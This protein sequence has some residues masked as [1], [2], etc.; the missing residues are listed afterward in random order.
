MAIRTWASIL[1]VA[2]GRRAWV[3]AVEKWLFPLVFVSFVIVLP[4]LS[5]ICGFAASSA[6]LARGPSPTDVHRGPAHLPAFAYYIPAAEAMAAACSGCSSR[7][8][9]LLHLSADAPESE[10]AD[11][12]TRVWLSIP[13]IRAFG[14][15][16]VVGKTGAIT[17]TGSSG[18][19]A[20]VHS[21]SALLRVPKNLS[22]VNHTSSAWVIPSR[23]FVE[24]CILGWDNIPRTLLWYF[25][26][27]TTV[28]NDLR[29][30]VWDD[31]P[32]M[33]PHSLTMTN[34]DEMTAWSAF[35]YA[36]PLRRPSTRQN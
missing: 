11:L 16:D 12:A 8:R 5:A 4:F 14:N 29:F 31:P 35:C 24:Y 2:V 34:Y 32:V 33:E 18:L 30:M 1:T 13:T 36:I 25:T 9:Y 15:V 26:N 6:F 27:N 22:F 23:S 10:R 21:A 17:P 19:A 7:N 28:N 3:M 20:T